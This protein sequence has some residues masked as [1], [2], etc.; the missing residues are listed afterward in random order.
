MTWAFAATFVISLVALGIAL[1]LRSRRLVTTP[2]VPPDL[3]NRVHAVARAIAGAEPWRPASDP[4]A[5]EAA[6]A[7]EAGLIAGDAERALAAAEAELASVDSPEVPA[8]R[9]WLAWALCAHQQPAAALEQLAR[10]TDATGNVAALAAYVSARAEH[11]KFE[12]GTGAAGAVPPLV[13]SADLAVVTLASGRGAATWLT[14][15]TD[16]QL[17]AAQVKMAISEHREITARCLV[18]A[19]EAAEQLPGF[20]DAAY[21]VA[22]LAVKAGAVTAATAVFDAAATAM[23]GRPDA[24]AFARDRRDL[25]DPANAVA[26]AKLGQTDSPKAK[27]SHRLRVL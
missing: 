18:R 1:R 11:L 15:G 21:L 26:A 4:A 7:I 13:T 5:P 19:L 24:E 6:A 27:R 14:G 20:A 3:A 17:T 16:V 12:H 23:A 10:A 2:L 9:V 25:A 8:Q 22:R